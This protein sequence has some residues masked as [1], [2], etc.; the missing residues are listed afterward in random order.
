MCLKA[1]GAICGMF[2][3]SNTVDVYKIKVKKNPNSAHR[4]SGFLSLGSTFIVKYS[5][6]NLES[7]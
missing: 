2:D 1:D 5:I 4:H 7:I 3:H 6:S